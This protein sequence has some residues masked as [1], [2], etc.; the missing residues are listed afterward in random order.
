MSKYHINPNISDTQKVLVKFWIDQIEP[1]EAELDAINE[2]LEPVFKEIAELKKRI[3][4][5]LLYT[6]DI[7]NN[8]RVFF[9]RLFC[10]KKSDALIEQLNGRIAQIKHENSTDI[11][12]KSV[13]DEERAKC[14]KQI[15]AFNKYLEWMH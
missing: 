12:R 13:L 14:L 1:V 2:R 10:K 8:I 7:F 9:N 15:E 11:E 3:N 6:D 5:E 4:H